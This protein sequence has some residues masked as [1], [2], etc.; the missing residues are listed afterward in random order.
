MGVSGIEAGE[1]CCDFKYWNYSNMT[2][3]T[4]P[5]PIAGPVVYTG[6]EAELVGGAN[7]PSLSAP[8]QALQNTTFLRQDAFEERR[9]AVEQEVPHVP[10]LRVA[11]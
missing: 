9:L 10:L 6:G 8:L 3:E 11:A 1:G 4:V 7:P 2:A 5:Q